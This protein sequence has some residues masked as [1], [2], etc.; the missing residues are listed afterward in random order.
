MDHMLAILTE[1]RKK[2]RIK[3]ERKIREK[4]KKEKKRVGCTAKSHV[5]FSIYIGQSYHIRCH[6]NI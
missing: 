3:R 4:Q 6:R 2:K 5:P 1:K